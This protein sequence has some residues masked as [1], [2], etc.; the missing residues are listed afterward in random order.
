[1]RALRQGGVAVTATNHVR[2]GVKALL[3]NRF[4]DADDRRE[5]LVDDLHLRGREAACVVGASYD[6]RD[7]VTMKA[8]FRPFGREKRFVVTDGAD[9]VDA[10]N[11]LGGED[12]GDARL[13]L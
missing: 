7:D 8:G 1:M 5:G 3:R 9:V 10:G 12:D 11:V 6:Q 4:A 2:V 13:R